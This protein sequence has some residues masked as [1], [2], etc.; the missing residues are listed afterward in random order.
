MSQTFL[1]T[2]ND[3][4]QILLPYYFWKNCPESDAYFPIFDKKP[5][6]NVLKS[7][8]SQIFFQIYE[9]LISCEQSDNKI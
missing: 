2:K 7:F 8:R 3:F 5:S 1:P 6:S 9:N 4:Y